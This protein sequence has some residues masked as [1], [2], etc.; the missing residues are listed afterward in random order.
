MVEIITVQDYKCTK[1][2]QVVHLYSVKA[3][4]QLGNISQRYNDNIKMP[5]LQDAQL[6]ILE[7]YRF[8]W[9]IQQRVPG[10]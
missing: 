5:K 7:I 3:K 8:C 4:S 1:N 10:P 6:E 2:T 9:K